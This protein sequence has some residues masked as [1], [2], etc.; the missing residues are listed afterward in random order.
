MILVDKEVVGELLVPL[1][2]QLIRPV[3]LI[4]FLFSCMSTSGELRFFVFCSF[5]DKEDAIVALVV[6]VVAVVVVL[7]V[8]AGVFEVTCS[9]LS[10][11]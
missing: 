11:L 9:F 4:L 8:A 6:E 10:Q 7:V 5:G 1:L 2:V 3:L